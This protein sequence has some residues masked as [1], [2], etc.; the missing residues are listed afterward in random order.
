MVLFDTDGFKSFNDRYGHLAGDRILRRIGALIGEKIRNNVDKG[1][2]YGGDE[3]T[4]ILPEAGLKQAES[5]VQ[6]ILGHSSIQV[7]E[8]YAHL[9]PDVMKAAMEKTFGR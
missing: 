4:I 8:Q 2:R 3:F 1:F 6:R 5:I 9:A 7:T